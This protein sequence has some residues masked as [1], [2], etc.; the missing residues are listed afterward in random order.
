MT[1]PRVWTLEIP[2]PCDWINAN[3]REHWRTKADKTLEWRTAGCRWAAV[4]KLP[5]L[6]R[7]HILA[8]LHFHTAR[9]RDAHNYYPTLKALV[10]GLID[11][12]LLA[13]D[14]TQYLDGPDIRIG[15]PYRKSQGFQSEFVV[16]TITEVTP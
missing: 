14:S 11:H 3:Q 1:E 6:S 10:D 2:A 7:A 12:G 13:D 8:R 4:A 9:R 5:T 16:L 15:F